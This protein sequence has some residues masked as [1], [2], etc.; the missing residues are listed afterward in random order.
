MT[1][2][3]ESLRTQLDLV[4]VVER[5]TEVE[6]NF[7]AFSAAMTAAT[8]IEDLRRD[9]ISATTGVIMTEDIWTY[10]HNGLMNAGM[11]I[12]R[13]ELVTVPIDTTPGNDVPDM[14]FGPDQVSAQRE[15]KL[16][17]IGMIVSAVSAVAEAATGVD[18]SEAINGT[19]A[20]VAESQWAQ[21]NWTQAVV[22]NGGL[23]TEPYEPT[24]HEEFEWENDDDHDITV[25]A[26]GTTDVYH[27]AGPDKPWDT[28]YYDGGSEGR[29]DTDVPTEIITAG[30]PGV[31][32]KGVVEVTDDPNDDV[33]LSHPVYQWRNKTYLVGPRQ[34]PPDGSYKVSDGELVC[35][36]RPTRPAL[37][38]NATYLG[39][40]VEYSFTQE[41]L[42]E[43][44]YV[45]WEDSLIREKMSGQPA[46]VTY[47][48]YL[49]LNYPHKAISNAPGHIGKLA[50]VEWDA[51]WLYQ[52]NLDGLGAFESRYLIAIRDRAT[53]TVVERTDLLASIAF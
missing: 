44:G 13:A 31:M 35:R 29:Y 38:I 41:Y 36:T 3:T 17:T 40:K 46:A 53:G 25:V 14:C 5:M 26:T 9:V 39:V 8:G 10:A 20:A 11:V 34:A 51:V 49:D 18:V 37:V 1:K 6:T 48:V 19:L 43:A 28:Y 52:Q 16:S 45:M 50:D 4:F 27:T 30:Y 21:S 32:S 12:A 23:L 7:A 15:K 2:Y 24:I 47:E 33:Y 22:G 42:V